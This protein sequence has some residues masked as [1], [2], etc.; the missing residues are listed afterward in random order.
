[1]TAPKTIIT[2]TIITEKNVKK[3]VY[4]LNCL[5]IGKHYFQA[6]IG[7]GDT[8]VEALI[9]SILEI[10]NAVQRLEEIGSELIKKI[11]NRKKSK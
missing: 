8:E 2:E 5:K 11:P 3:I 4:T 7:E 9:D 10:S 6:R 1:M